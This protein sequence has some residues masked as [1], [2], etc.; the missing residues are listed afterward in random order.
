MR[1]SSSAIVAILK[2]NRSYTIKRIEVLKD[3][4]TP[5][6]AKDFEKQLSS[7]FE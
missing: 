5:P 1:K 7:F 3:V 4:F 6:N 2:K